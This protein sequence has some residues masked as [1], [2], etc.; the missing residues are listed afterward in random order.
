M[1][2]YPEAYAIITGQYFDSSVYRQTDYCY[3]DE[4]RSLQENRIFQYINAIMDAAK[5]NNL[6]KLLAD[7]Q[8]AKE[9]CL[10]NAVTLLNVEN[11]Y[12]IQPGVALLRIAYRI[13]T[14]YQEI[15]NHRSIEEAFSPYKLLQCTKPIPLYASPELFFL[16]ESKN[17]DK[18]IDAV[19]K[20]L[21]TID[22]IDH[23]F[24]LIYFID[25]DKH[26]TP[27]ELGKFTIELMRKNTSH[28]MVKDAFVNR[29][30][31]R[32]TIFTFFENNKI[33][34]LEVL[35]EKE[36]LEWLIEKNLFSI[37]KDKFPNDSFQNIQ[38]SQP[39]AGKL[40]KEAFR[41]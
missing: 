13:D 12:C 33:E 39:K 7:C 31:F 29:N 36:N 38:P 17:K 15:N 28:Q 11:T 24:R 41:I 2:F 10:R 40:N 32:Q 1:V 27:K 26:F 23:F 37:I 4:S 19:I 3:F 30:Y 34:L 8:T 25:K 16:M 35:L 5:N 21:E 20:S 9:F 14:L 6:T 22:N 18:V